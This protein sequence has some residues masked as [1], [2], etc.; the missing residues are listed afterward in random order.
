M[1]LK[2]N[3]KKKELGWVP[4]LFFKRNKMGNTHA[5]APKESIYEKGCDEYEQIQFI[6][7]SLN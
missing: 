6:R 2:F 5:I 7:Y 4:F 1:A 3:V